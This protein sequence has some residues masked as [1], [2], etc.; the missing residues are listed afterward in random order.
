MKFGAFSL[1]FR[2]SAGRNRS[3]ERVN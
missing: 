1:Q 2:D 3:T